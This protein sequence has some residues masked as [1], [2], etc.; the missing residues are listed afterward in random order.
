MGPKSTHLAS[1]VPQQVLA[2]H[3]K[4]GQRVHERVLA[5]RPDPAQ[6]VAVAGPAPVRTVH[7]G[8]PRRGRERGVRAL[9]GRGHQTH[10]VGHRVVPIPERVVHRHVERCAR[11]EEVL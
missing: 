9:P 5:F 8:Q 2:A 10:R 4:P 1:A 6:V 7:S 11:L 3:M